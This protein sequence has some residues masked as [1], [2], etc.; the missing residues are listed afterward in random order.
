MQ[1]AVLADIHGNAT[2]F[3]ECVEY[4]FSMASWVAS[5]PGSIFSFTLRGEP[6]HIV[7]GGESG[8]ENGSWRQE[9]I[10]LT[11]DV[12]EVIRQIA[13][14]GMDAYAPYW[15]KFYLH[16]YGLYPLFILY[17]IT[18]HPILCQAFLY[19]FF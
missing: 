11:Y 14:S 10:S 17:H 8:K 16:I 7:S 9:F 13:D 12:D 19:E 1:L 5:F 18:P 3:Q 15:C 4:A 2:A 6:W